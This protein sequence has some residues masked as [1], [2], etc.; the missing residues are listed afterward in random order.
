MDTETIH[1]NRWRILAVLCLS[2][3]IAV[4]DTTIVNVALPSIVDELGATT[5]QLQWVVDAYA[6]VFAGLLIACGSLGDRLGRKGTLQIGL[7][8]FALFST[9]GAF[10][11]TPEQLIAMRALMGLGA[12][13]I[14]PATLAIIANVFT[15]P[16]ERA[17]AIGLW[18][19][20]TGIA[21]ALGPVAGG[22]LLS[23]F[24]WGSVLLVNL[25]VCVGAIV[26]GRRFIPTSRD[27]HAPRFDPAGLLL[28][29]AGIGLLVWT[30]I[31][32][33]AN[34]WTSVTT[35]GFGTVSI[36]LLAA[37]VVWELRSPNPM[38]DVRVFSN[39]R[40]SAASASV[41]FTFF[42]LFGFI[43]ML[44]QYLQFV[45]GYSVLEAGLRTLPFAVGAGI[46]APLAA[47]A[48]QVIGP[49]RVVVGG[50]TLM[51]GALFVASRYQVTTSYWIV[52]LSALALGA[53]VS[54]T[55]AP[56]TE[57]IMSSLPKEKAGVGSAVN[58]TTREVGGTLGVAVVGSLLASLYGSG[59]S[60][61][62]AGTPMPPEAL[63][64]AKES[65]G[66]AFIVAQRASEQFGPQAGQAIRDAASGAFMDGFTVG[67]L[68][69]G[70]VAFVGAIVA[71]RFLPG[72]R[73]AEAPV[74]T[75]IVTPLLAASV[76]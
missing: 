17:K 8:L 43:F 35:V 55:T 33:P 10:A 69:A 26:L 28:S 25:P 58:D 7:G 54:L 66:A 32:A 41:T 36:V 51:A 68:V 74:D 30:V 5:S 64:A 72:R 50:L 12:A 2:L 16:A 9:V 48:A 46:A 59:I 4:V 24:W 20:V 27:P 56:A 63:A 42:A 73:L 38:L 13:L 23:R 21:V 34:G 18:S 62:L 11:Q 61:K 22:L 44:T 60:S 1:R 45:R 52:A 76:D 67:S 19:A 15:V 75:V 49:K 65:V 70:G 29:I 3:F 47:K 6:L 14:F 53:G 40:F 71:A 39:A 31:E 37:F 57:S